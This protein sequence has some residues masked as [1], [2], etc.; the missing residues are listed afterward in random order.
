[1][2]GEQPVEDIPVLTAKEEAEESR[3]WRTFSFAGENKQID[4]RVLEPYKRVVSHGGYL[5]QGSR[6]AIIVFSACFLPDRSRIDYDYVMNN[7]FM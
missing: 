4:L 3:A 1:V 6:N 5:S 2:L 7:L